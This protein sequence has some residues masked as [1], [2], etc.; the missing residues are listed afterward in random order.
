MNDVALQEGLH[1]FGDVTIEVVP[2]VRRKRYFV[3]LSYR[4]PDGQWYQNTDYGTQAQMEHFIKF[5]YEYRNQK[6]KE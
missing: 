6:R 1:Q 2:D 3:A 4:R 5:E